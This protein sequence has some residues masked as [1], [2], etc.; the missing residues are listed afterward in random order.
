LEIHIWHVQRLFCLWWR[1]PWVRWYTFQCHK[2]SFMVFPN[3][4]IGNLVFEGAYYIY[5]QEKQALKL[6]VQLQPCATN[7]VRA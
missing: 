1:S 7:N 3:Y 2:A 6:P 4:S 5:L